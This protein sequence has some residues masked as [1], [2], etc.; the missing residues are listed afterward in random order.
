ME[1]NGPG[2]VIVVPRPPT[3]PPTSSSIEQTPSSHNDS[4]SNLE[5]ITKPGLEREVSLKEERLS[6]NEIFKSLELLLRQMNTN[7][8]YNGGKVS[9]EGDEFKS[10]ENDN[11]FLLPAIDEISHLA[12]ISHSVVAYLGYLERSQLMRV[13]EQITNDMIRWLNYLFQIEMMESHYDDDIAEATVK[14]LRIVLMTNYCDQQM[15]E[16]NGFRPINGQISI[17]IS[18]INPIFL[19]LQYACQQLGFPLSSIR[20]IPCSVRGNRNQRSMSMDSL[21]LAKQ[22]Q[23][24]L[25]EQRKPLLLVAD[26]SESIWGNMDDLDKL[27]TV[28]KAHGIWIHASGHGLAALA[29]NQESNQV[30]YIFLSFF[31]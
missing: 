13:T 11:D 26:I 16:C 20:R 9:N 10:I 18:E 23:I 28:C 24:D 17:Y 22:V 12:L 27:Y 7:N 15:L 30:N 3:A 25:A 6:T 31:F 8:N 19:K 2:T 21:A 29:C 14:L 4:E 5:S 1:K